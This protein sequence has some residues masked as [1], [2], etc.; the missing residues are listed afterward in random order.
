MNEESRRR[1]TTFGAPRGDTA[2]EAAARAALRQA[3]E[4]DVRRKGGY[5]Q[6]Y[7]PNLATAQVAPIFHTFYGLGTPLGR[8]VVAGYSSGCFLSM[9]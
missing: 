3:W 8:E 2:G 7:I 5:P 6:D 1:P 4:T 9:E